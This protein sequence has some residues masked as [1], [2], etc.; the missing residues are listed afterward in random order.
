MNA[1]TTRNVLQF[2]ARAA[3][4]RERVASLTPAEFKVLD[5][6][7]EGHQSKA[8]ASEMG[9]SRRTVEYH[10]HNVMQ[11]M[12]ADSLADLVRMAERVG[13]RPGDD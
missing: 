6:L 3:K 4:A 1:K 11:K 13:I 12:Q 2:L 5:L 8:I 10:R 7:I 9:I